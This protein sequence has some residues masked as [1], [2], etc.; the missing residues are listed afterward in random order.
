M[1]QRACGCVHV[2]MWVCR[3]RACA[4]VCVRVRLGGSPPLGSRHG[5]QDASYKLCA[6]AYIAE[7]H[8]G[9]DVFKVRM[10]MDELHS[11]RHR[12]GCMGLMRTQ[13]PRDPA[14]VNPP[15][16]RVAFTPY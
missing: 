7:G 12:T 2:C 14:P 13:D 4:C 5:P 6:K 9:Y 1:V 3:V 16:T 11:P 10:R 15:L 8:D